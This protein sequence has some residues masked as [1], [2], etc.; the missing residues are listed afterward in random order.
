MIIGTPLGVGEFKIELLGYLSMI[1][2]VIEVSM[3]HGKGK[4]LCFVIF[5]FAL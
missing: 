1:P 2:L 5:T 3:L 4:H